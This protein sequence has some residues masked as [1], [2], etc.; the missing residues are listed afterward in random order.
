MDTIVHVYLLLDFKRFFIKLFC[1]ITA[2]VLSWNL[3]SEEVS[4]G[5]N[6]CMK[7]HCF[8]RSTYL[9]IYSMEQSPSSEANQ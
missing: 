9:L 6:D 3:V 1:S 5:Q 4:R 8:K 7:G 2:Y